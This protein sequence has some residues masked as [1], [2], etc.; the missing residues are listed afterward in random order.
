MDGSA[1][2]LKLRNPHSIAA[3]LRERPQDVISIQLSRMGG[4]PWDEV[5]H[6]AQKQGV[7]L[8][9]RE[10]GDLS[11]ATVLDRPEAT[12]EEL[13]SGAAHRMGGR[14]IWLA[15]D[16]LQDPQNV[17]A[18]FRSAAFFGI[19]G[20]LLPRDRSSPL[21]GTVYDVASGGLEYVPHAR[22]TNMA[23]TLVAAREEGL[24]VLGSSERAEE[25]VGKIPHDRPWLVVIGN[26][27]RGMRRNVA[28]KC[29]MV[30]RIIPSGA[31]GSLNA[32]VA[33]GIMMANLT[34]PGRHP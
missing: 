14:G 8:V 13:F 7:P 17:G 10:K 30:C 11:E 28:D 24:W 9:S 26:E 6:L 34:A 32:A 3:A 18:I 25:D 4:G 5:H 23:R 29:D 2:K 15:L 16:Q 20:V 12:P 19:Q 22:V 1:L 33:A 31:V 21:S 27:E